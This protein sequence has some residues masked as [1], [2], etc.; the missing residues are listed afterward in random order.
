VA[1]NNQGWSRE[2][3][4]AVLLLVALSVLAGGVGFWRYQ[5]RRL[6]A[7][8]PAQVAATVA[9]ELSVVRHLEVDGAPY[10]LWSNGQITPDMA[11][12][13]KYILRTVAAQALLESQA[14]SLGKP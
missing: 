11:A 3:F 8:S 5:Q 7:G 14:A 9:A 6:P 13:R 10:L 1:D 12:H 4:Y 2:A